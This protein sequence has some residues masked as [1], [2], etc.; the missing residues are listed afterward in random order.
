[1]KQDPRSLNVHTL[2]VGVLEE[3][4]EVST[5]MIRWSII[6]GFVDIERVVDVCMLD[7]LA[8]WQWPYLHLMDIFS[9][10]IS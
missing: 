9:D 10:I 7:W 1:M 4:S 6:G 2:I 3:G 8:E 5:G